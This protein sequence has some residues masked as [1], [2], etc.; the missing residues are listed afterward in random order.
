MNTVDWVLLVLLMLSGLLGVWRGVVKE[1]FSV[2]AW[3]VGFILSGSMGPY[4]FMCFAGD[5]FIS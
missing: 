1:V 4:F 2:L 3:I 5:D